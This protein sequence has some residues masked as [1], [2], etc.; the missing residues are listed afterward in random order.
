MTITFDDI[1]D[2]FISLVNDFFHYLS[3]SFNKEYPPDT[4]WYEVA[5]PYLIALAAVLTCLC[6][7]HL[8]FGSISSLFLSLFRCFCCCGE[9]SDEDEERYMIAPGRS[10][11][12]IARTTFEANPRGYFRELRRQPNDFYS[13]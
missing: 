2:K 3:D 5:C 8:F 9:T 13:A 4:H 1:L 10:P 6:I 7:C 11:A 12:I